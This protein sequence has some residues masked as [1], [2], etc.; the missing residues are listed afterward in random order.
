MTDPPQTRPE[1]LTSTPA[2]QPVS[3]TAINGGVNLEANRIMVGGDVVGRD[4]LVSINITDAQQYDVRGLANPYLGLRSFTC[5]D[6]AKYAGREKLAAETVARLTTLDDPVTL[7]FV[8]G[9][10][11]SGK[12]SFVQAGLLPRLESWYSQRNQ[13][14]KHAVFRPA[15][16]PL[17][18]F[19]DALSQLGEGIHQLNDLASLD[20]VNL[21]V[22]DQ[23][24]ELFTQAAALPRDAFFNLLAQL[25]PF[26]S[27][28]TH[29]IATLRSDYLSELFALTALYDI[30]KRGLD[31]RVMSVDELREALQQPLRAMYP[32]GVKRFQPELADRLAQDAHEDAAYLPL[33]QVTLEEIWRKGSLTLGSYTNLADAIEQSADR[34]LD[35][36]DYDA[37]QPDRPRSPDEQAAILTLCLDL[38]DVSPDDVARRDVRRRR[39][40]DALVRGAP[41]RGRLI[42]A[43]TAAR[44]LSVDIERGESAHV[45][46]DLIHETLLSNWDRLRQAIT[47]R[48]QDLRQRVRFEQQLK[49]WLGHAR[50]DDYL[51]GGVYLAE[52]HE[53][54]RRDDIAMQSAE[55]R[56]FVRRSI[57][58][59]QARR[60]KELD[61]ARRIVQ[62]ER[63]AKQNLRLLVA[64]LSV[65]LLGASWLLLIQPLLLRLQAKG[66]TVVVA[67]GEFA[68]GAAEEVNVPQ[69]RQA[70]TWRASVDEFRIE[71]YEVTNAQYRLCVQDRACSEPATLVSYDGDDKADLPVV[72]IT[73]KQAADYCQWIGRRLPTEIEWEWAARRAENWKYPTGNEEPAPRAINANTYNPNAPSGTDFRQPVDA[74]KADRGGTFGM[75][76][77]VQEWTV[78]FFLAYDDP[79][80][81]ISEWRRGMPSAEFPAEHVVAR[82][83]SFI[84]RIERAR[85]I[86]RHPI[87]PTFSDDV[88]GF[89]CVEGGL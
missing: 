39:S 81:R 6:H 17:L 86:A 71:Q 7:L 53:L 88:V 30:A 55:A 83:G 72:A 9:A 84:E 15:D 70:E 41:D 1:P 5:A 16:A 54:E 51:L 82:G 46:V 65:L 21:L 43:L 80:Y 59:E 18:R 12:S 14:V 23:F 33:L 26:R 75:A 63:R 2:E 32:D 56:D 73:L 64:G 27:T 76:G 38:V 77:N 50:V 28:H 45:D 35:Y 52:A 78:S 61:D 60:Q 31:L 29:F 74:L 79:A 19:E 37:A 69:E 85:S 62:A 58:R 11:G 13:T 10:S 22:V 4:K 68:P 8:T 89:R 3:A 36:Q 66:E 24:E 42:D 44:L 20:Q 34:V 49:E 25:P 48:R 40:K 67:A 57:E 87:R 47:Q